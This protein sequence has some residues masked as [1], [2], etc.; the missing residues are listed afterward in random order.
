[1][2]HL[3]PLLLSDKD[4]EI[5]LSVLVIEQDLSQVPDRILILPRGELKW[6]KESGQQ[7]ALTIDDETIASVKQDFAAR[8]VKM[9]IDYEHQTQLSQQNGRPAPAAGWIKELVDDAAGLW[10][11]VESWTLEAAAYLKQ[12]AYRYTSPYLILSEDMRVRR[13]STV[14]LTNVPATVDCNPLILSINAINPSKEEKE[15]E[16]IKKLALTLGLSE[17]ATEDEVLAA[18]QAALKREPQKVEVVPP[19][20]LKTLGLKDGAT[21]AEAET[22]AKRIT[23]VGVDVVSRPEFDTLALT[24]SAERFENKWLQLTAAGLVTAAQRDE[25]KEAWDAGEPHF[26][27]MVNVVRSMPKLNLAQRLTD[28]LVPTDTAKKVQELALKAQAANPRLTFSAAVMQVCDE[29]PALGEAYFNEQRSAQPV[30]A[31]TGAGR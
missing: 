10:G 21:A 29:T 31:G 4:G 14:S 11:V 28:R 15:M 7:G 2:E 12:L 1:M 23:N 5:A 25:F 13:V 16:F 18:Q 19:G 9:V 30:I 27:R 8:G 22:A 20:L 26:D 17:N 3:K 6:R 24:L